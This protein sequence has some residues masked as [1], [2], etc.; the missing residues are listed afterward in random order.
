M[1]ITMVLMEF[2]SGISMGEH[3]D[4]IDLINK[5]NW[6]AVVLVGGDFNKVTHSFSFF[7]NS[8]QA[9]EW[10]KNKNIRYRRRPFGE[11]TGLYLKTSF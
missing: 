2:R 1:T 9:Q 7:E 8:L 3:Q 4:L 10:Y 11:P 5:Y 6:K